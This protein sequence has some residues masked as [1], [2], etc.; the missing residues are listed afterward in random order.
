MAQD[1]K[2]VILV[3]LLLDHKKCGEHKNNIGHRWPK[4]YSV[5]PDLTTICIQPAI[6]ILRSQF[7][8]VFLK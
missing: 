4:R 7:E 2:F 1:V 8:I 3:T 5:K 6:T